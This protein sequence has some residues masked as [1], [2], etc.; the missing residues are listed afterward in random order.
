MSGDGLDTKRRKGG[1]SSRGSVNN[2]RRLEAFRGRAKKGSADW[3][4]CSPEQ[5]Q[6]VVVAITALGGA[7]TFSLSRDQGAHGLMLMLDN[8]RVPLW[9]N[10]DDDL[11]EKLQE[12]QATILD[13]D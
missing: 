12:V 10:G 6:A 13:D 1:K 5:L 11:D 2:T 9:F 4:G 8:D 3:G 7:V